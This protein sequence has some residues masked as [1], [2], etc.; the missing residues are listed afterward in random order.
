MNNFNNDIVSRTVSNLLQIAKLSVNQKLTVDY[1]SGHMSVDT[2]ALQS[3][4][5]MINGQNRNDAILMIIE[6]IKLCMQFIG[7]LYDLTVIK[8]LVK[9]TECT[10]GLVTLINDRM[11]SYK[12]LVGALDKSI[13][14]LKTLLLTYNNDVTTKTTLENIVRELEKFIPV[15]ISMINSGI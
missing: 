15:H 3:V 7:M 2:S 14:G 11:H 4:T 13:A 5:R 6:N 12:E 9:E 10:D 8:K 1:S